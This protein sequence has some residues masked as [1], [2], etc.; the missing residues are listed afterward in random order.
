[1]ASA[2]DAGAV[3]AE[4]GDRLL[5]NLLGRGRLVSERDVPAE[6][7]A[8]ASAVWAR[9]QHVEDRDGPGVVLLLAGAVQHRVVVVCLSGRPAWDWPSAAELAALQAARLAGAH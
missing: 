9:E 5:R 6:P 2:K 8:G 1:M 3:L 7:F 4:L